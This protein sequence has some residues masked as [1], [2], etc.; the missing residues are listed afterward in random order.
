MAVFPLAVQ[1]LMARLNDQGVGALPC[2]ACGKT[3]QTLQFLCAVA[4][5]PLAVQRLMARP[6]DQGVGASPRVA[7]KQPI[8]NDIFHVCAMAP[9]LL[10]VQRIITAP[11]A[12]R[13]W[14]VT[15]FGRL[16]I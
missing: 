15:R 13:S 16:P 10:P 12:P 6:N 3:I 7:G 14:C 4:V 1:R 2:A 9:F 8:V 5:F 11:K